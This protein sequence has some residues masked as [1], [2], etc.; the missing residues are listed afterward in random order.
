MEHEK[1]LSFDV[2][3]RENNPSELINALQ[4]QYIQV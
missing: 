3:I 4:I 1:D 2:E